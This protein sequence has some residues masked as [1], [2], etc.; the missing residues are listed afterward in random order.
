MTDDRTLA[1]LAG[2]AIVVQDACNLS[3][4]VH[5]WS[6]SIRRLREL[7]PDAGTDE[8]NRHPI[9]VLFA[10]KCADLSGRPVFNDGYATVYSSCT[11]LANR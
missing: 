9:N 3:G 8:I 5:A 2:E 4:V 10:D 7:L 1:N 6:R 11:D